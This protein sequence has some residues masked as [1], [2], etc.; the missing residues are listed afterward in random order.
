MTVY[1]VVLLKLK[2]GVAPERV[3][4]IKSAGHAMLGQVP[5]RYKIGLPG[6]AE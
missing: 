4:A 1:H 6:L 5:G 3:E 2:E